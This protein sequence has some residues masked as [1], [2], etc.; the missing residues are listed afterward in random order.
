ME[1]NLKTYSLFKMELG[2]LFKIDFIFSTMYIL[3][4]KWS[5]YNLQALL[6]S[7]QTPQGYFRNT[8]NLGHMGDSVG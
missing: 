1:L 5:H 3:T 2:V 8:L 7:S 6:I 4:I